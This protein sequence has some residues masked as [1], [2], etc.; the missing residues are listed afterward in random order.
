MAKKPKRMMIVGYHWCGGTIVD[1]DGDLYCMHCEKHNVKI[2]R[3][4]GIVSNSSK[5][6]NEYQWLE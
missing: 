3:R 4:K 1:T 5:K 2:S 6:R